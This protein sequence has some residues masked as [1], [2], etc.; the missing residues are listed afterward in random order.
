MRRQLTTLCI[1]CLIAGFAT[2]SDLVISSGEEQ[3]GLLEL[4]T[5]EGCSSCP[6][7]DR[8]LSNLKTDANL[9]TQFVPIGLHVDYWDYIGWKDRFAS[10]RF[11]SRQ[12]DYARF[13]NVSTV[14]TPGFVYNGQEWRSWF[15]RPSTDFPGGGNP[16]VLVLSISDRDVNVQFLP[17]MAGQRKLEASLAILGFGISTDVRGGE[18]SGRRLNHDFVVLGMERDRLSIEGDKHAA[19][20]TLPA[21]RFEAERFAVAAWISEVGR[22]AP[23]QATGGWLPDGT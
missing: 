3:V 5:S 12:R 13:K 15:G 8:W 9:W 2:A 17:D 19:I 1:L 10:P 6:P 23:L 16:G 7:A 21:T 14:Y 22:P 4:Y 11:S 20:M 18:N